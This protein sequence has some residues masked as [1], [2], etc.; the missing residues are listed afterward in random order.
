MYTYIN[1]YHRIYSLTQ[2]IGNSY[3]ERGEKE[4]EREH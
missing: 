3:R 1:N 2:Y 4:K